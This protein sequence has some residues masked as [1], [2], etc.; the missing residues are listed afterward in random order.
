MEMVSPAFQ[1][2]QVPVVWGAHLCCSVRSGYRPPGSSDS[3]L[4]YIDVEVEVT[5][6][7][8]RGRVGYVINVRPNG[9]LV[10]ELPDTRETV[11]VSVDMI[12]LTVPQKLDSI[13]VHLNLRWTSHTILPV[14][15]WLTDT[16]ANRLSKVRRQGRSGRLWE[17]MRRMITASS[18]WSHLT[19]STLSL[20]RTWRRFGEGISL[21]RAVLRGII[22]IWPAALLSLP[23][24]ANRPSLLFPLSIE[25]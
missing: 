24:C 5:G 16:A 22:L 21:L 23:L 3:H 20:S 7:E 2:S 8:Y 4:Q 12:K 13:K 6:D 17:L 18:S 25:S 11:S 15:D 10:V 14:T 19:I 1:A 9:Q